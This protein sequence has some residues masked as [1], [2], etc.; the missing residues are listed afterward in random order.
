MVVPKEWDWKLNTHQIWL[1]PS[2]E[3]Y[4]IEKILGIKNY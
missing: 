4:Y 2:E 1:N 3:S